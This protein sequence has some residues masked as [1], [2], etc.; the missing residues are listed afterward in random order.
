M[1]VTARRV[2]PSYS[3]IPFSE[4]FTQHSFIIPRLSV[5]LV[6]LSFYSVT[7]LLFQLFTRDTFHLV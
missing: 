2:T 6:P 4:P 1:T 3:T 5:K 7:F